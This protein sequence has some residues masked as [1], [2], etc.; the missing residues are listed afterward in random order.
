MEL[1]KLQ[2]KLEELA[3]PRPAGGP[4]GRVWRVR[5]VPSIIRPARRRYAP[6]TRA[7]GVPICDMPEAD[8]W[9]GGLWALSEADTRR[10]VSPREWGGISPHSPPEQ[11]DFPDDEIETAVEIFMAVLKGADIPVGEEKSL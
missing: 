10:A 11:F 3:M 2:R 5:C 4:V 1:N 6:H 8:A 7:L 9:V